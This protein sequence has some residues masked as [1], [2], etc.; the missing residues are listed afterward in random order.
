MKRPDAT[1]TRSLTGA[2]S[3]PLEVIPD[4]TTF[5]KIQLLITCAPQ[6]KNNI[7]TGEGC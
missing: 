2:S 7:C 1:V 5:E 6:K 3:F 4:M